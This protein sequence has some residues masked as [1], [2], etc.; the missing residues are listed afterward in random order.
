MTDELFNVFLYIYAACFVMAVAILIS[1][2]AALKGSYKVSGKVVNVV[3]RYRS[4]EYTVLIDEDGTKVPHTFYKRT[5]FS[6]YGIGATMMFYAIPTPEGYKYKLV[7]SY[8]SI[9]WGLLFLPWIA[10][11][12]AALES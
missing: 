6:G 5:W 4:A 10:M 9:V 7:S 1:K 8:Y 11:I 2:K 3:P 12:G